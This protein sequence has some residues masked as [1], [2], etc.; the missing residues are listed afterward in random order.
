MESAASNRELSEMFEQIP[1]IEPNPSPDK[2]N[3]DT[4][5]KEKH[6]CKFMES[7]CSSTM[8]MFQVKK[9]MD[10]SCYYCIQHPV[11]MPMEEFKKLSFIPLPLMMEDG[12]KYKEFKDLY[13]KKPDESD[14]PSLKHGSVGD[15][16]C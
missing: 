3:K 5:T 2:I 14:R 12:Q 6:L 9:C 4:L 1:F 16:N 13:E 8:Y 11:K 15:K 10:L 7:H